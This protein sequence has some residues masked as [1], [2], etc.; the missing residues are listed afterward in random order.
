[1]RNEEVSTRS[2]RKRRDGS[3]SSA[4]PRSKRPRRAGAESQFG[5]VFVA[6]GASLSHPGQRI[7]VECER[8]ETIEAV[9]ERFIASAEYPASMRRFPD[10]RGERHGG[11]RNLPKLPATADL[12]LRNFRLLNNDGSLLC[13]ECDGREETLSN[14]GLTA[15]AEILLVQVLRGD[16][17]E[18]EAASATT[19]LPGSQL[20]LHAAAA[21]YS[22]LPLTAVERIR[23]YSRGPPALRVLVAVCDEQRQVLSLKQCATLI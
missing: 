20:L 5:I 17:G 2:S 3:S 14:L 9:L 6:P 15:G 23:L 18:W 10:P 8:H 1:M 21:E 7:T 11:P 12:F 19:G 22:D 4:Q 13:R 16:I